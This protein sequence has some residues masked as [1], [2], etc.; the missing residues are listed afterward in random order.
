MWRSATKSAGISKIRTVPW[1][2]IAQSDGYLTIYSDNR[3]ISMQIVI[4][5]ALACMAVGPDSCSSL[6]KKGEHYQVYPA[7]NILWRDL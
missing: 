3:N 4:D 2:G 1:K 7:R 6:V 5:G